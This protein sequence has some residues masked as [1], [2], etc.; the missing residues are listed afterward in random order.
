MRKRII[1][2]LMSFLLIITLAACGSQ[3]TGSG[4]SSGAQG[5]ETV[6][7]YG[8]GDYTAINPALYEHGEINSL[9]FLGLTTHDKDNN[10]VPGIAES[11]IWDDA[12]K[13]Y[14]FKL[15]SGLTFHDG[16]ALTA[17]D[18]KFTLEAIMDPDNGSENISNYED[19]IAVE[20]LGDTTVTIS[21]AAPNAAMPDY[22]TMG[23]LPRHLLEGKDLATDPWNRSP[24]GAGSYKFVSWD[25][26]Q[27]ITMEKFDGFCL[28]EPQIDTI[29][30]KIVED[31]DARSLQLKSGELDLAQVTPK[32]AEEFKTDANF[33]VYDMDTADYR[34]IM[35]NFRNPF[36][37]ENPGLPAALSYAI[38]REAIVASVLL[39]EGQIAYSPIQKSEFNNPSVEKY[40]YSPESAKADI[41]A[42]GW[43]RGAD[44]YYQKDGARLAFE[45]SV[46]PSDQVRVDMA[47]ICAQNFRDIGVNCTVAI[48]ERTDWSGQDA[49][50]IG[51]GSPFDPDD[52]TYKVFGTDK[53][54]N[55]NG[56]SNVKV[57][58]LLTQAR[59]DLDAAARKPLYDEF[60]SEL[61]RDP[62][63]TFI[64][65]IDAL[66]IAKKGLSGISEETSLGHH[67]V[68][69]FWNVYEWSFEE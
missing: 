65:Y 60:Q 10:V 46:R 32:D 66:Y 39:G 50:L 3:T 67:G 22:L 63:Y 20:A 38:D 35:Y 40:E 18:V 1:G 24:V 58:R 36:W 12:S 52:H 15:R 57:D 13:T 19:I 25:M 2:L 5:A 11:W 59:A 27:S 8:S 49:F 9:L 26:G 31:Y 61:A 37:Q 34:G 54:A 17:A 29:I 30:F 44:G 33:D 62:A 69:I 21:L 43:E 51:W 47:N 64:A 41:E 42:L 68:G 28:G 16:R 48:N 4:D 53:G 6:L 14:T 23:I 45:I 56:Y 7:V 55:Y